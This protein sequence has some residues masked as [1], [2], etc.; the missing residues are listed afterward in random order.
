MKKIL[1]LLAGT[2]VLTLCA[3]V[4]INNSEKMPDKY[5]WKRVDSLENEG[6]Y[7]SALEIVDRIYQQAQQDADQTNE[8]KAL[9]YKLK[10][11]QELSEDG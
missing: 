10:Y 8:I 1:L 2:T 6:L 3:L 11:Q 7:R 4:P 5:D 9:I